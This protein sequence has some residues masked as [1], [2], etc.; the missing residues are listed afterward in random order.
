MKFLPCVGLMYFARCFAATAICAMVMLSPIAGAIGE[1]TPP[2]ADD[3]LSIATPTLTST[4]APHAI[5]ARVVSPTVDTQ[6]Q[7][8][9]RMQTAHQ[10]SAVAELDD[11]DFPFPRGW[12]LALLVLLLLVVW[13][14]I[15][16]A[17]HAHR[18]GGSSSPI[19][20]ATQP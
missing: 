14:R 18:F 19:G 20:G 2:L 5:G 16:A 7:T 11:R 15:Q 4:H 6:Q 3:R 8:H 10:S 12:V 9:R 1:A 17:N 13:V